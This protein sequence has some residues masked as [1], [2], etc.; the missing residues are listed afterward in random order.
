MRPPPPEPPPPSLGASA[1]SPIMQT[2]PAGHVTPSHASTQV[3]SSWQMLPG[4]HST[5]TQSAS[6][7]NPLFWHSS[8]SGQPA[9]SHLVMHAPIEQTWSS[10]QVM[11]SHGS[12]QLP[13]THTWP[14]GHT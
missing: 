5:S 9:Q 3:P 13:A 12:R 1:H 2:W 6:T 7:H 4:G 8:P 11:M 14:A 10:S